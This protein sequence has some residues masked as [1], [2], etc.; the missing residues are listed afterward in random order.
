MARPEKIRLGDVLVAQKVISQAQ[1]ADALDR[2]RQSGRKLGRVLVENGYA[3]EEQISMA[4]ARQMNIPFVDLRRIQ[5]KPDIVR[6]L[7]EQT[8]RRFRAV[9]LENR[10]SGVLVAMADPTDIFAYDEIVRVLKKTVELAVVTESAL[11]QFIDGVYRRTDEIS[12]LARSLSEELGSEAIDISQLASTGAAEDAPVVRLLQSIF[13]DA[14]QV[15]ASDIHIEPTDIR[16]QIRVRIDGVL[17]VSTE[18]DRRIGPALI[19]RLKLM[20]E[21]D[22]AEKRLP[23]DGR[24]VVRVQQK[25]IDVRLSVIPVQ[26]GES[27]VMRLL[28]GGGEVTLENTGIPAET[29]ERFQRLI[30]RPNGLVLVT[31]PTGSGKTTTLYGALSELNSPEVKILTVEDPVEYRLPGI[32]QVQVAEKIDLTFAR[33]LR[34]FLRQDPDVILVGEMRDQETALIALRA[35]L[36]GHLVLSTLHTNDAASAAARLMDMG[37]PPYL[38]A[39]S[40]IGIMAQRLVRKLCPMCAEVM[41][42]TPTE[43]IWLKPELDK[44]LSAEGFKRGRGCPHCNFT[45]YKGRQ[46]VFELLEIDATLAGLL[47][48]GNTKLFYEAAKRKL[49][50]RTL[51]DEAVRLAV[52]GV[53]SV[54]EAMRAAHQSED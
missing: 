21:M 17:H 37:A 46:G 13:E 25:Q 3:S 45:G 34:A 28:A 18:A 2:Q 6:L 33:A 12:E 53:T 52:E 39:S 24:F 40:L 5:V 8:A 11:G 7:P 20:G 15:G 48:S 35:A 9:V 14:L 30:H 32:N 49:A 54:A 16:L 29:L 27:A 10:D 36:T 47:N 19:Q 44:G 23:Q 41:P 22:I 42:L 26:Y 1:L 43:R 51:H 31:G 38:L 4:I 50:G